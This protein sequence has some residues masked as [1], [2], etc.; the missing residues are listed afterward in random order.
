MKK[1]VKALLIAGLSSLFY[2]TEAQNT[3][4]STGN[5]GIGTTSPTSSLEV[6]VT[7]TLGAKLRNRNVSTTA[8]G[9]ILFDMVNSSNI[10]WRQA[11]GGK[12]NGLGINNG[13]FYI[14]RSGLGATFLIDQSGNVGIG[15]NIPVA[16]F[17]VAS[18]AYLAGRFKNNNAS[19]TADGSVVIDL[20]NNLNNSWRL[21]CSGNN[22]G[23]GITK[24]QFYIEK[25]GTGAIM[26]F[27]NLG[28]VLIGKVTQANTTYKLDVAGKIRANE[29]VV[30]TT[31]ADFVFDKNYKLRP[32][33]EVE[34]YIRSNQHLPE[35]P[36]ASEM[37]EQGM[38]VAE[39][40]KT[41][42]QKVEELTLYIIA[43]QKQIE[44]LKQQLQK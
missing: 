32:L 35:V 26:L 27:S 13:Q 11:V 20:S 34:E 24:D 7:S 22:N 28:N 2:N 43:Q 12:N 41:L 1:S 17:D 39:L 36:S 42:L 37:S 31:G 6:A 19:A 29:V 21:A 5:A 30:N 15:V 14:E 9:T 38:Q 44:E 23:I 8:D 40:S 10:M 4:P 33:D 16:K 18:T 25:T 3:F